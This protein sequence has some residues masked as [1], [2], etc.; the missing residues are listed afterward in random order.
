MRKP[1]KIAYD[2]IDTGLYYVVETQWWEDKVISA[3]DT[4][5]EAAQAIKDL[6]NAPR[7]RL[8]MMHT[9]KGGPK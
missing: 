6:I 4:K 3:H 2:E 1:Y 8:R 9:D 5:Q 7:D